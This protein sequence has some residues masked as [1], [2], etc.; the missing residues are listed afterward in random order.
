MG[1]GIFVRLF[2]YVAHISID[3][4]NKSNTII[5][6]YELLCDFII[7]D[8]FFMQITYYFKAVY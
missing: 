8:Y 4:S 3:F 6:D 5:C 1:H 7:H 2:K